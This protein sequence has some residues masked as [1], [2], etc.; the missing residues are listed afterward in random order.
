MADHSSENSTAAGTLNSDLDATRPG[1]DAATLGGSSGADETSKN[2]TTSGQDVSEDQQGS[3]A[4]GEADGANGEAAVSAEKATTA[5]TDNNG[6][7]SQEDGEA[8]EDEE[9]DDA[10]HWERVAASDVKNIILQVL[11]PYFDDDVGGGAAAAPGGD[12]ASMPSALGPSAP[13]IE[14]DRDGDDTAQRYDHFKAEEWVALVCD[15]IMERLVAL[16]KPF[17]FVVHA[18]VMR[19]CGAGVH[20]CSSCYYAPMDGWLSHAHDLSAHLY[21]VVTVYWCAV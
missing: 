21:V 1:A 17:K 2:V 20:V 9:E 6:S 7:D 3:T 13:A 10:G 14:E 18:M 19:K 8:D 11:S 12:L 5:N 15:G 16:G 4:A